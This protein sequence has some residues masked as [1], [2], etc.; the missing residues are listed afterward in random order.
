MLNLAEPERSII[1]LTSHE[2][3]QLASCEQTIGESISEF[4]RCGRALSKIRSGRLYRETCITFNQYLTERWGLRTGA[5]DALISS[6]HIAETLEEAGIN[7]PPATTQSA[8]RSLQKLP[9]IEGLRAAAWRYGVTICPGAGCPT[10]SVLRRI[11]GL[12]RDA[13]DNVDGG[14]NR[15]DDDLE[16]EEPEEST[17]GRPLGNGRRKH[18]KGEHDQRFLRALARLASYQGFSVPSIVSQ[19][20]SEAMASYAWRNCERLKGRLSEV[21]NAI[22]RQF[23]NAGPKKAA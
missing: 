21:E 7:L 18:A 3:Q 5:A 6:Y 20:G 19:I 11:C 4:L 17:E 1:K 13:L 12:I 15:V 23:P 8:M 22:V 16:E 10:V 9:A 14:G 2:R